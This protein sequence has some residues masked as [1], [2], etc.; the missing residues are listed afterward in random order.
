MSNLGEIL[1][2]ETGFDLEDANIKARGLINRGREAVD[3]FRLELVPEFVEWN[4]WDK[5]KVF[6]FNFFSS[7][8]IVY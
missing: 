6:I 1:K 7:V 5:W 3:R 4:K 2:K 8:C